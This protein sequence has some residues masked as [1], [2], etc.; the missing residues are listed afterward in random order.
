MAHPEEGETNAP[1]ENDWEEVSLTASA[2]AAAPGPKSVD[3]SQDNQVKLGNNEAETSNA[4]FMSGHFNVFPPSEHENLPVGPENS[5]VHNEKGVDNDDVSQLVQEE[6]R[7]LDEE[8]ASIE[9]LMS[10]D[11]GK[12]V[13]FDKD[14]SIYSTTEFSSFHSE[15]TVG[16]VD[17]VVE[18]GEGTDDSVELPDESF[19]SGSPVYRKPVDEDM[20]DADLPCKAWWKRQAISLYDHAKEANTFWSIFIA[21][22]VMGLVVIG[23]QWQNLHLNGAFGMHDEV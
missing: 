8:N 14:Q 6:I 5:E 7:K 13:G 9:G 4:L 11:F 16:K 22:A 17:T 23:H 2:Y 15:M 21:A 19:H 10:D 20:Y 12:D 18:E 3:T 1:K